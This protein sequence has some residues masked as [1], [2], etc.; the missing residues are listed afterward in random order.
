MYKNETEQK[1]ETSTI[2]EM[3]LICRATYLV[4]RTVHYP[5]DSR[6]VLVLSKKVNQGLIKN[7]FMYVHDTENGL[8]RLLVH[9]T[10]Y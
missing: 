7:K 4:C 2:N 5:I 3:P 6:T 9:K 10:W 1:Q 8:G